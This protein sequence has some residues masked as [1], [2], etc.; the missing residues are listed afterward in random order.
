MEI[1]FRTSKLRKICSQ[2]REMRRRCGR[3]ADKIMMRLR[4]LTAAKCLDDIPVGPPAR[5]HKYSNN[6]KDYFTVDIGHP[7]RI[8]FK[9][10]NEPPPLLPDGGIDL[11]Q[12]TEIEIDSIEFDPH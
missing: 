10:A 11:T 9:A 4:E 12:V 7:Y 5:R 1:F 2:E 6:L 3:Q 8:I